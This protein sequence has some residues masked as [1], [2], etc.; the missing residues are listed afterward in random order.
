MK[1]LLGLLIVA[2]A[3]APSGFALDVVVNPYS[4]L[5]AGNVLGSTFPQLGTNSTGVQLNTTFDF[6]AAGKLT[7]GLDTYLKA[8]FNNT[9]S[10]FKYDTYLDP[11]FTYA[12]SIVTVKTEFPL[13]V[14]SSTANASVL[15]SILITPAAKFALDK[16]SAL[17]VSLNQTTFY[18]STFNID[19]TPRVAYS[20]GPLGAYVQL[21]VPNLLTAAGQNLT[22]RPDVSY[23]LGAFTLEG[24]IDFGSI[25]NGSTALT[26]TPAVKVSY[27]TKVTF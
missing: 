22:I 26:V 17:T 2:L 25:N 18:L 3:L 9:F 5:N 10:T 27:S 21:K 19:L 1:R 20:N 11:F 12:I 7:V 23:K 4:Q 24:S 16:S 8:S 13:D 15:P 14:L 6:A